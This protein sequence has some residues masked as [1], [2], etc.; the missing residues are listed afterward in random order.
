[1]AIREL[2]RRTADHAANY[3]ESLPNRPVGLPVPVEEMR[4]AFGGELPEAGEPPGA[5]IDRL[6]RD[7]ARGI[8]ASAGPRF[9]G[10]VV[11]GTLP[12]ALAADWLASSWDQNA[13]LYVLSPAA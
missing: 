13:G 4:A 11:G 9:F 3:L 12:A 5:V 2:L 6:A 10:F 7:A 8:V 1:M